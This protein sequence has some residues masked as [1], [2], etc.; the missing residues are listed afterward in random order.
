MASFWFMKIRSMFVQIFSTLF[1]SIEIKKSYYICLCRGA[2]I[3]SGLAYAHMLVGYAV[4]DV[5]ITYFTDHWKKDN[6]LK[7]AGIVNFLE[8]LSLLLVIVMTYISENHTTP[9]KVILLLN[10]CLHISFHSIPDDETA[11]Y[12]IPVAVLI[13]V[14]IAGGKPILK[15]FLVDQLTAHEPSHNKDEDRIEARRK[16]WWIPTS[17]LSAFLT[18]KVFSNASWHVKFISSASVL[19]IGFLLFSCGVPLYHSCR[20]RNLPSSAQ[21]KKRR[22]ARGCPRSIAEQWKSLSAMIPMWT[23]FL[24]FGLVRSTGKTFFTEQGNDMDPKVSIYTL[25][26]VENIVRAVTTGLSRH[27]QKH[28][29]RLTKPLE[30]QVI[31][32]IIW[33]GM[34]VSIF[35]SSVA[36]RVEARRLEVIDNNGA[37]IK[38]GEIIPMSIWWLAPQFCLMGVME[39]LA[40]DGLDCFFEVQV[41]ESLESYGSAINEAVIGIGSFLN[42]FLV[43]IFRTWFRDTLNC[44]RLDKYYRLLTIV[45]FINLCYYWY[46]STIYSNEEAED[47]AKAEKTGEDAV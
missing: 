27:F 36:W 30:K 19:G 15:K 3:T 20:Y 5:L 44:S 6:L 31:I 17:F 23:T 40:I 28:V 22:K 2:A 9:V 4:V 41:S 42:G 12:F 25:L 7:A 43:Y 21:K 29:K 45:S 24:V 14:G 34:V 18:P 16:V 10:C 32:V 8:G 37:C 33:I 46:V 13:S 38:T 35:C 26:L 47:D 39:G 11:M 1:F